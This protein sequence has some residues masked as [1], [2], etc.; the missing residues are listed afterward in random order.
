MRATEQCA[1]MPTICSAQSAAHLH[2]LKISIASS[3]G[4]YAP[5]FMLAPASQA[6]S[7]LFVQCQ[8]NSST[9]PKGLAEKLLAIRRQLGL[10]QSEIAAEIGLKKENGTARVSEYE[11]GAREPP[12]SVLL[13]YARVAR[14][15]TCVLIDNDVELGRGR[16]P[17]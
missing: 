12:L 14:V 8:F 3:P 15:C 11:S 9:K 16:M 17:H 10:S 5:G 6:K 7:R 4:A 1:K 13:G 2:G